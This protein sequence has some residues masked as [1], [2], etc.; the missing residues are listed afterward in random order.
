MQDERDHSAVS[1]HSLSLTQSRNAALVRRGMRDFPTTECAEA[2][3]K[4]GLGLWEENKY[5]DAVQC[6]AHVLQVEP[7]HAASQFHLGL[8]FY[9]GTGVP[10][11]DYAQAEIWWRKAAERGNP[12]AQNNLACIYQQDPDDPDDYVEAAYWFRRAA[13]QNNPT[14]QFNLGVMC[15]IGQGLPQNLSEAATWYSKAAVQGCA[16]AQFNLGELFRLGEGVPQDYAQAAFWYRHAAEQQ[17]SSAQL[18]LAILY[19]L[20][21]GVARD[22]TQAAFW[23]EQALEQGEES[24]Q[25]LLADLRS[26]VKKR[27]YKQFGNR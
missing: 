7:D 22:L 20:G 14:A 26:K 23:C 10:K 4:R 13:E 12:Q 8:A 1:A 6:F 9:H 19:A 27:S 11:Q 24:A 5:R 21:E 17:Q 16:V 15:Q 3:Y 25:E 18:N 2:L